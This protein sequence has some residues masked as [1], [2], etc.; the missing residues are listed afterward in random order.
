MPYYRLR[1][2]IEPKWVSEYVLAHYAQ[3]PVRHGCPLGPIPPDIIREQGLGKAI[4]MYRPW[5]PE[6]DALVVLPSALLL[7][8]AKVQKFMDGL[9][10]LPVYKS[11]VP[12]TPELEEYA[13]YNIVMRLLV[14][15]EIPW[16]KTSGANL[17]VEVHTWATT[18]VLKIW[19]ERDKGWTKEAQF[20]RERRKQAMR[21]L[22][23][24]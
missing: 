4:R 12:Q 22:G 1:R 7:I 21:D 14:P 11:L 3:Y 13:K 16:V 20:N 18:E 6:V 24:E 23:F 17:G 15:V 10:K 5:R 8:E 19:E 9:S 2:E